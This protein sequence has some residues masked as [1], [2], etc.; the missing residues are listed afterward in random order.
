MDDWYYLGSLKMNSQQVNKVPLETLLE[1]PVG[2]DFQ[3][4]PKYTLRPDLQSA[5]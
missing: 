2:P 5:N 4:G 1:N 3:Y